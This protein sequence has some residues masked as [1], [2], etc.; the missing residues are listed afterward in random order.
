MNINNNT[1]NDTN[2]TL[3]T[4]STTRTAISNS[5]NHENTNNNT[6][7]DSNEILGPT[8]TATTTTNNNTNSAN[9]NSLENNTN[10]EERNES[11]ECDN[12]YTSKQNV[13]KIPV[14]NSDQ[15]KKGT[16]LIV[17]DSILAGLRQG[18]FSRSKR[19]R[20]CYFPGGKLKFAVPSNSL[21]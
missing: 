5:T 2:S 13:K 15:W 11:E 4:S 21:S 17:E 19:I 1:V 10:S 7:N 20:M 3:I 12:A 9:T 6:V 16:T 18:K 8:D 14:S